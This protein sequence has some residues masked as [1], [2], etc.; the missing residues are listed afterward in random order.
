MMPIVMPRTAIV[1]GY[2][3]PQPY[4]PLQSSCAATN[5][6]TAVHRRNI[7]TRRSL[8]GGA[9]LD[10]HRRIAV[11]GERRQDLRGMGGVARLDRDVELGAL[12]RHVEEQAAVIDLQDISSKHAEPG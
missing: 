9:G 4:F 10:P 6:C 11:G 2:C 12:G 3:P 8:H 1:K 5:R 7:H